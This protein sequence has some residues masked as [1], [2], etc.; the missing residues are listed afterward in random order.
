MWY[1]YFL[2]P[3]VVN[4]TLSH[5][6]YTR[7]N[8]YS[9]VYDQE[10]TFRERNEQRIFESMKLEGEIGTGGRVISYGQNSFHVGSIAIIR[11][12]A[13]AVNL[14]PWHPDGNLAFLMYFVLGKTYLRT[15]VV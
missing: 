4:L 1:A 5:I 3:A 8:I 10:I 6:G 14:Y 11:G 9:S 15:C 2:S 12:C 13:R 7:K